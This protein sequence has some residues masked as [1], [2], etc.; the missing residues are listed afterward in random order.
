[1]WEYKIYKTDLWYGIYRKK[2]VGKVMIMQFLNWYEM[3]SKDK[4]TSKIYYREEDA[5][6]ALASIKMKDG[7][8]SD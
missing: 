3:W 1:M 7:K 5:T 8:E 6:W 2:Y 4:D